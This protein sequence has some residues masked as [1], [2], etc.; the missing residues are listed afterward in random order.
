MTIPAISIISPV[1]RAEVI[2]PELVRRIEA[3]VKPQFGENY[4]IVLVD[5]RSPDQSWSVMM[6]LAALNPNIKIVRLS[7]NFGQ[8]Y[9]ITAGLDHCKGDM[10]VIMDCDLQDQ[11]EEI[12]KLLNKLN[13]GYDFVIASRGERKDSFFKKFFSKTFHSTLTYL[14]GIN[15]DASVGNFGIYKRPMIDAIGQ[16]RESIRYFP[17]MRKWVG[18]EGATVLVEHAARFEGKTTYNF[19][20]L[21]N[22]AVDILLAYSDKPMRMFVKL[23]VGVFLFTFLV[24]IGYLIYVITLGYGLSIMIFLL[25][26]VWFFFGLLIAILGIIGL[27]LGKTFENV[28]QRPIY[29]VDKK[30]NF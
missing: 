26:S 8:H 17:T 15:H 11:P 16:M 1:Y 23:G 4:E 18:Y 12:P 30:I 5:D 21:L 25:I 3:V 10:V 29:I 22:L 28:K 27:Y 19:K 9:A 2:L 13:E 24:A 7:R 14:T 6:Q 20:K